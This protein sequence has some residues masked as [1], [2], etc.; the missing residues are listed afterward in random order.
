[1]G[2]GSEKGASGWGSG[3]HKG[4]GVWKNL[5]HWGWPLLR[6]LRHERCRDDSAKETWRFSSLCHP[7]HLQMHKVTSPWRVSLNKGRTLGWSAVCCWVNASS[8]NRPWCL[9]FL[10]LGWVWLTLF[11]EIE[12]KLG[13]MKMACGFPSGC[14]SGITDYTDIRGKVN[15]WFP[16]SSRGP[17][18]PVLHGDF[19]IESSGKCWQFMQLLSC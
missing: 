12:V 13:G 9:K 6:W 16:W 15:C 11:H 5:K 17:F 1:M 19:W 8:F 7:S 2:R 10:G 3:E 4:P 18:V 14:C